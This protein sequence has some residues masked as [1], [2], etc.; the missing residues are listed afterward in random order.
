[1]STLAET[2]NYITKAVDEETSRLILRKGFDHDGQNFSLSPENREEW[3]GL[4]IFENELTW[5]VAI[6]TTTNS[7]YSLQKAD[8]AAFITA[9]L[10]TYRGHKHS[11]RV[12][13]EQIEN[14]ST[15]AELEAIDIM[16]P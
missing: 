9:G 10:S 11:G 16:R 2:K 5:P 12:L 14:T 15:I 8:L 3:A 1:V 6:P 7:T 13:K 4:K